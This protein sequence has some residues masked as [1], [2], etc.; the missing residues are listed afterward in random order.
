M[1]LIEARFGKNVF[2]ARLVA[3]ASRRWLNRVGFSL[4]EEF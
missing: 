2:H 3:I 1:G 4:R